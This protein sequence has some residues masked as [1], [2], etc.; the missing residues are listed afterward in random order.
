MDVC[1]ISEPRLQKPP[2]PVLIQPQHMLYQTLA[3]CAYACLE[4]QNHCF[5][6]CLA[7]R[8]LFGKPAADFQDSSWKLGRSTKHCLKTWASSPT[9]FCT[10]QRVGACGNYV[11]PR[12]SHEKLDELYEDV[13]LFYK[14]L[15]P[16]TADSQ[17]AGI[18]TFF[19]KCSGNTMGDRRNIGGSGT[20]NGND[21]DMYM[22]SYIYII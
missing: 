10:P 17:E 1:L 16:Q 12:K 21:T 13:P 15:L 19:F 5:S 14:L 18:C 11:W 4:G 7:R 20:E 22:D 2:R 3:K 9:F 6:K 8:Y